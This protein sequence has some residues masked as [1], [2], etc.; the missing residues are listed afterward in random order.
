MRHSNSALTHCYY[1]K[2]SQSW[3]Q[4]RHSK[5]RN[6]SISHCSR[7]L[8]RTLWRTSQ[9]RSSSTAATLAKRTYSPHLHVKS[10]CEFSENIFFISAALYISLPCSLFFSLSPFRSDTFDMRRIWKLQ[11]KDRCMDTWTM[12]VQCT[13]SGNQPWGYGI[14][15]FLWACCHGTSRFPSFSRP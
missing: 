2:K 7:L 9:R 12:H 5:S 13:C 15:C 4:I 1:S 6:R 8:R 11:A 10:I 14:F 3:C